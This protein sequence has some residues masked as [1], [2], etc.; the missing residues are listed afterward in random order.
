MWTASSGLA[1]ALVAGA[2]F[3]QNVKDLQLNGP[4]SSV[5]T[6]ACGTYSY[7][8]VLMTDPCLDLVVSVTKSAGEPNIYISK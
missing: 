2:V 6:N 7:F 4:P 3:G 1:L 8:S 5:Y